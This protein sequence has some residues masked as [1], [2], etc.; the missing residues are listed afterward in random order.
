MRY[1]V[2][3]GD[4]LW[5][6]AVAHLGAGERWPEIAAAS[7]VH[8]P[9]RL[10]PGQALIIPTDG[11]QVAATAS[12]ASDTAGPEAAGLVLV[13]PAGWF[14]SSRWGWRAFP[15]SPRHMHTGH[16]IAGLLGGTPIRLGVPA[17]V[18][19]SGYDADGYG[20]W[21]VLEVA[22]GA[23]WLLGHLAAAA[24]AHPSAGEVVGRIGSTGASTGPHIHLEHWPPGAAPFTERRDPE[25]LYRIEDH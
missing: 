22:G 18:A 9:D 3:P 25:G 10:Y 11:S 19:L 17:T 4:T 7:R 21:V 20:H 24:G 12:H 6:L 5:D 13:L 16:D 14:V 8:H 23:R 1:T 15:G 2:Q